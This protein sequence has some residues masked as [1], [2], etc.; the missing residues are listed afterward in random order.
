[1]GEDWFRDNVYSGIFPTP[2][3]IMSLP[4]TLQPTATATAATAV[5]ATSSESLK[6]SVPC[7]GFGGMRSMHGEES[8][9][10]QCLY[11]GD[12]N[13]GYAT[14]TTSSPSFYS[15]QMGYSSFHFPNSMDG[16]NKPD[17]VQ[18]N[19]ECLRTRLFLS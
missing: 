14:T 13:N 17:Y 2:P 5:T 7:G 3:T 16:T 6:A 18:N 9:F 10:P 1:M 15:D 8:V 11:S 12:G 4:A 19:R